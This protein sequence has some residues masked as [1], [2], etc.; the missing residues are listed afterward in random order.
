MTRRRTHWG[1]RAQ[2]VSRSAPV[3]GRSAGSAPPPGRPLSPG[4]AS[5]APP[6]SAAAGP[7]GTAPRTTTAPAGLPTAMKPARTPGEARELAEAR[8]AHKAAAEAVAR[9]LLGELLLPEGAVQVASEP[10]LEGGVPRPGS[11]ELVEADRY[12]HT[13]GEPGA[14]VAWIEA[15]APAGAYVGGR[16]WESGQGDVKSLTSVSF[17][18]NEPDVISSEQVQF[19]ATA[20]EGGGTALRAR[21]RSSGPCQ[22]QPQSTSPPA[23]Q[24]SPS[25]QLPARPIRFLFLK[26]SP[27]RL[28]SKRWSG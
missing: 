24:R 19:E 27:K 20:A 6:D 26:P 12:W 13:R 14:L 11:P 23:S 4:A 5:T 28:A 21:G 9:E 8:A 1:T 7:S 17:S 16:G 3:I 10:V 25:A 2:Y 15:H 22:E 18:V